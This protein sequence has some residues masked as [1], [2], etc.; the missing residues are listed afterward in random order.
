MKETYLFAYL[1]WN[2]IV[3][4]IIVS[5]KHF[6]SNINSYLQNGLGIK[7]TTIIFMSNILKLK[8]TSIGNKLR[9]QRW[10]GSCIH[11]LHVASE[12]SVSLTLE[13]GGTGWRRYSNSQ[14]KLRKDY[15]TVLLHTF[16][17]IGVL[18]RCVRSSI[19]TPEYQN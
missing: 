1:F 10:S 16:L 7:Y 4:Q 17:D 15:L 2:Y 3:Q 19:L 14:R 18:N 8:L 6:K 11:S 9:W 13:W 5:Q 12:R